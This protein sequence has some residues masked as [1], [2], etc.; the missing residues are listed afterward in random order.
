[1]SPY[2]PQTRGPIRAHPR[3]YEFTMDPQ[4]RTPHSL[5]NQAIPQACTFT[6]SHTVCGV[7]HSTS[8]PFPEPERH[9]FTPQKDVTCVPFES[10][11][12]SPSASS[13]GLNLNPGSYQ[14]DEW[15]AQVGSQAFPGSFIQL[16]LISLAHQER[17]S[18]PWIN[19]V[20]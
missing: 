14:S 6:H 9:G 15:G 7:K 4:I 20:W 5:C 8:T 1:V 10:I 17:G 13:A 16:E 19:M 3:P 11:S 18:L 2:K 12:D